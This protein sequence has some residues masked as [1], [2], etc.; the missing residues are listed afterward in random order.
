MTHIFRERI[1]VT[2]QFNNGSSI[3][4]TDDKTFFYNGEKGYYKDVKVKTCAEAYKVLKELKYSDLLRKVK[5]NCYYISW[6][7]TETV[8]D[9]VDITPK[10]TRKLEEITISRDYEK[11]DDSITLKQLTEYP[12]LQVAQFFKDHGYP[13]SI[14]GA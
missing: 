6:Q 8:S 4:A 1:R 11:L 9:G 10:D 3:R 12:A 5:E 13:I 14:I 7:Y 2:F